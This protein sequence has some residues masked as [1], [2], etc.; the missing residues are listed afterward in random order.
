MDQ[1]IKTNFIKLDT[2]LIFD[3]SNNRS[4]RVTGGASIEDFDGTQIIGNDT[5]VID[6]YRSHDIIGNYIRTECLIDN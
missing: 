5:L 4:S 6:T 1:Y 2:T 3:S